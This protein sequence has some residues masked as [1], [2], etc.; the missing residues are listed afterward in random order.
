MEVLCAFFVLMRKKA[1]PWH[2]VFKVDV[3]KMKYLKREGGKVVVAAAAVHYV[4]LN[5]NLS[6]I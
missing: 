6:A 5:Y 3:K 4:V 1:C 2:H